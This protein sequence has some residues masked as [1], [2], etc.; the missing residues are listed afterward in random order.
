[1]EIDEP[2]DDHD[3]K[4]DK[5]EIDMEIILSNLGSSI[6]SLDSKNQKSCFET[7]QSIKE[8]AQQEDATHF[9]NVLDGVS[10]NQRYV[11]FVL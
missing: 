5:K 6:G 4:D 10:E 8:D 11:T 2:L 7:I 3:E 9:Q 1:M